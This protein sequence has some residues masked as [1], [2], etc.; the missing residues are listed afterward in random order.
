M[1]Y[2]KLIDESLG[3][4]G[5]DKG[6]IFFLV[7]SGFNLVLGVVVFMR[8]MN[9]DQVLNGVEVKN[10]SELAKDEGGKVRGGECKGLDPGEK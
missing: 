1:I 6:I 3:D 7:L 5:Y 2:G 9:S 4:K 10:D 8:D